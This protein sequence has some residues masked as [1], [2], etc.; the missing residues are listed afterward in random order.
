MLEA[1]R[2]ASAWDHI[3]QG[4]WCQLP[5]KQALSASRGAVCEEPPYRLF[6][7]SFSWS[8]ADLQGCSLRGVP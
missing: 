2:R 4:G 6:G 1:G 3:Q 8:R 7:M 5:L